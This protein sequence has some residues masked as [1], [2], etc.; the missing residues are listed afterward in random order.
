[1]QTTI[2]TEVKEQPGVLDSQKSRYLN[3]FKN[4]L[5]SLSRQHVARCIIVQPTD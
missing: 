1:M 5:K 4:I 3:T 2:Q